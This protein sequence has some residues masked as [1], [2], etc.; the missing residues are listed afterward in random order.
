[1]SNRL[2]WRGEEAASCSKFENGPQL[3]PGPDF[4]Y[5]CHKCKIQ[6]FVFPSTPEVIHFRVY[7]AFVSIPLL[8]VWYYMYIEASHMIYG[9]KARLI[10]R[11]LRRT[12][13]HQCLKFFYHMYGAGTGL[14][15]IYVKKHD[16]KDEI[17][18]WKRRGEQSI[19][20]LRG[21]IQ[22]TCDKSHQIIFEAVRGISVRSDI[23]I[24]D[25]LFQ[26]GPC[27]ETDASNIFSLPL[28]EIEETTLQ[29]SGYSADFNE[30]EY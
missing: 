26:P 19:T 12:F 1:M 29:S 30:I 27:K 7:S 14:L 24:D 20:W 8:I 3:A 11:L 9:Q 10:S 16:A 21:L 22:Y 15:N 28:L 17:L 5:A 25:I 13:G 23:A 2:S 6:N 18:I 4:G